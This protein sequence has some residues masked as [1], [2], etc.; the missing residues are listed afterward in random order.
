MLEFYLLSYTGIRYSMKNN[1]NSRSAITEFTDID[2]LRSA[3]RLVGRLGLETWVSAS[4][5]L[6][7]GLGLVS[8]SFVARFL[9]YELNVS[10]A[11]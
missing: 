5:D 3:S 8:F 6:E 11:N 7:I 4:F 9:V 10:A 2:L 1:Y